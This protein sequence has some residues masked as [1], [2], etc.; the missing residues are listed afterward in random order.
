MRRY[1]RSTTEYAP[2]Y[3]VVDDTIS[4]WAV[5]DTDSGEIV[6]DGLTKMRAQQIADEKNEKWET[7]NLPINNSIQ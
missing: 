2:R 7:D 3:V 5:K 4:T 1:S 6:D